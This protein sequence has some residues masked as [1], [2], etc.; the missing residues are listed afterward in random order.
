MNE[1]SNAFNAYIYTI[2][3]YSIYIYMHM[4]RGRNFLPVLMWFRLKIPFVH[5]LRHTSPMCFNTAKK[6]V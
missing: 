6:R 3:I 5:V 4:H 2:Y 1:L